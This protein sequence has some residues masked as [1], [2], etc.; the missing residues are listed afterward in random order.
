MG[1]GTATPTT[2]LEIGTS[3][4]GDGNAG[5][6]ITLGRNSNATNT[7]A[8]SLNFMSKAGTAG[9][10]W[11]D[12]AG[13]L[14]INTAAPTN[15]NDVAG[16]VIG[17]QS[18]SLASKNLT[19]AFTDY[20]SALSAIVD[21]PLYDFTYKSGAY[22]NQE[23]TGII[24]DYSPIFGMDRDAAHPAGKSL[25][26]ITAIGYTFGAIKELNQNFIDLNVAT[27]THLADLDLKTSDNISTLAGLQVSVDDQLIV[28]GNSLNA[29]NAKNITTDAKLSA[30]DVYFVTEESHLTALDTLTAQM[31][32]DINSQATR[33]ALLESTV[34]T[35][36]AQVTAL[37]DFYATFD[38]GHLI[39]QDLDGNV[40]LTGKLKA[41][42]L[43]TGGLTIEVVDPLAPTIGTATITPV[44]T[45][46]DA[47]GTD[48]VTGSDGKTVQVSTRAMI[49]MVKGSRI[50]TSFKGNP[51]A[52]SWIEKT[53]DTS[54]D[55][56]GFKIRLS[57]P[58]TSDVKVDWWLIEQKDNFLPATP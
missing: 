22:N 24:T 52:F 30:H 21:A 46:A 51:N 47:D 15:A 34:A 7:G 50:F 14:R 37:T 13:Q 31:T 43:E 2:I 10:V 4:L 42:I 54:G 19:G 33:T 44:V 12:N 41:K 11:Q 58:V 56:I 17:T 28:V 40:T 38:L 48:D 39:A 16:T 32:L 9:Y 1:I 27:A 6:I 3:D 55:Y 49:P 36:T 5:P 53:V 25:N 57:A 45:D 18:S 35:L 23:F 26:M 8:G 29:L 20:S